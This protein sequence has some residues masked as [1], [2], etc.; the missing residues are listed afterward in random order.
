MRKAALESASWL[1]V[2][3][4]IGADDWFHYWHT[5]LDCRGRGDFSPEARR[6]YLT[7]YARIFCHLAKCAAT[8]GKPFQLWI[9]VFPNDSGSDCIFL[10]TP[11]PHSAFPTDQSDVRWGENPTG[12]FSDRLAGFEIREG[13]S[14][15]SV[16]FYAKGVGVPI[17]GSVEGTGNMAK[18][19]TAH[20]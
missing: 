10:H 11:N 9:V 13:R 18:A 5:H 19:D 15:C 16:F 8:A 4:N 20:D 17:E 1:G 3:T 2:P 12:L 6:L 7:G 14:D